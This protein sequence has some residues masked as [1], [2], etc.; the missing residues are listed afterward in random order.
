MC[1]QKSVFSFFDNNRVYSDK[2]FGL[3]GL[4]TI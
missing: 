2:N 1:Y 4:I 3:N